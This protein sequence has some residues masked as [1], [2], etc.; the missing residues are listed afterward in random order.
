MTCAEAAR[1]RGLAT[2]SPSLVV[3]N[4]A[5]PRSTP[6]SRPAAGS[7]TG[8]VSAITMTYQRRCSRLQLQRLDRA[9]HRPVLRTLT[10]P[11]AW[12]AACAHVPEPHGC[13][14]APSPVTNRTWLNRWYG[15]NRG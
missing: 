12:K 9:A 14:F 1:N 11:T 8:W 13:H 15:L 10:V 3:R 2:T 4:R 5:T 6:T 7:G